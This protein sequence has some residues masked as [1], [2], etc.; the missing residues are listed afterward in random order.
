MK[1]AVKHK[2]L[3]YGEEP[4]ARVDRERFATNPMVAFVLCKIAS[5]LKDFICTI[6]TK[7]SMHEDRINDD[8]SV[9]SKLDKAA[10]GRIKISS[11]IIKRFKWQTITKSL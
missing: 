5:S 2:R 7:H 1:R 4:W 9:K 10:L 6:C 8:P 11:I 3:V